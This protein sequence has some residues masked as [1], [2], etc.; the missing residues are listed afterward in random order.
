MYYLE[1]GEPY[2]YLHFWLSRG[3]RSENSFIDSWKSINDEINKNYVEEKDN[4]EKY[5]LV[6]KKDY[7]F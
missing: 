3:V 6:F 2:K 7:I 1:G 5:G 4:Y